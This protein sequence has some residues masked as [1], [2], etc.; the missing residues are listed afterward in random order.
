MGDQFTL[1]DVNLAPFIARLDGLKF[2]EPWIDDKPYTQIWWKAVKTRPSYA[3]GQVGPSSEEAK[4]M[5]IEGAKLLD[6][7]K[8]KRSE[9]LLSYGQKI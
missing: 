3:Q 8:K 6:A 1:A 2:V 7:F 9:Y 5:G 4:T